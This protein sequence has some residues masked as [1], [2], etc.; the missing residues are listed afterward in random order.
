MKIN[1]DIVNGVTLQ[2]S[3]ISGQNFVGYTK[4]T[5]SDTVQ[6]VDLKNILRST[7]L[8]FLYSPNYKVFEHVFFGRFRDK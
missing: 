1:L 8:S 7:H 6:F 4:I 5:K 3:K 2:A